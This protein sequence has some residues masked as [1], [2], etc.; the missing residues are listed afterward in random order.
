MNMMDQYTDVE[1]EW[2]IHEFVNQNSPAAPFELDWEV[3]FLEG[4][5][6]G[7]EQLLE[8]MAEIAHTQEERL[9]TH[10]QTPVAMALRCSVV[11]T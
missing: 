10:T 5:I 1:V 3:K 8:D 9:V 4:Q 7:G 11:T 6:G 2:S